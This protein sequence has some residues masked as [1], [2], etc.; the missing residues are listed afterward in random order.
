M[1]SRSGR[2]G[3]AQGPVFVELKVPFARK[4]KVKVKLAKANVVV[5]EVMVKKQCMVL[6]LAC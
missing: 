3:L 4:L 1:I 2:F 6:V 5:V